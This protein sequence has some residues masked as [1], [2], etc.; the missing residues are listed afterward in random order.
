MWEEEGASRKKIREKV[1]GQRGVRSERR[2][3]QRIVQGRRRCKGKSSEV[4]IKY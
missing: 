2:E 1:R 3:D 4:V